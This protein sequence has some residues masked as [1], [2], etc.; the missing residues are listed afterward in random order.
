MLREPL[1]KRLLQFY[2]PRAWDEEK[3]KD[4]EWKSISTESEWGKVSSSFLLSSNKEMSAEV[5][6]EALPLHRDLQMD[7]IMSWSL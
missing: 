5:P 2:G 3:V 7:P 6:E 1:N 4:L